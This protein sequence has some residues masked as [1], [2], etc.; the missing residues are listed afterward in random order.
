MSLSLYRPQG[1]RAELL[2]SVSVGREP[3]LR[4]VLERL[5]RW[6]PGAS[7]QHY[8]FIGPR[9]IGK[10]HL[11]RLIDHRTHSDGGL[12]Q[13]WLPILLA[14]EQY[15]V[16]RVSD[17]LLEMV[18]RLAE[19]PGMATLKDV[20]DE[21]RFEADDKRVCDRCLDAFRRLYRET[22]RGVLLMMENLDRLLEQQVR[23][24]SEIHRLRKILIEEDW[25]VTLCTSPTFLNAVSQPEEPF[26]EFFDVRPLAELT[27]DEQLEMLRRLAA[28]EGDPEVIADVEKY[29]SR[30]RA[31]HH[32]TGGSPRLTVM[33]YDLVAHRQVGAVR[34]EL[35]LLHD[36]LTPFYQD[37]MKEIS[38]QEAKVLET[39]ALLPEGA[40]PSELAHEARMDAKTVRATLTRLE[41]GGYVRREE[42]RRK[43]TVYIV[44][45]R[46]FRLWHQMNHSRVV[47]GRV[48]YLLE[49]FS[50]WYATR[51]ERDQIWEELV[52]AFEHGI[53]ESDDGADDDAL[54][55][56]QSAKLIATLRTA[57][58]ARRRGAAATL[59]G[60]MRNKAAVQPLIRALE[61]ADSIVRGSA[62]TAL[63]RLGDP[64]AVQPLIRALEDT[65]GYVRVSSAAA[66]GRMAQNLTYRELDRMVQILFE[67]GDR[68]GAVER[69]TLQLLP[70]LLKAA[71]RSDDLDVIL[72]KIR[73]ISDAL[74]SRGMATPYDVA[75][76]YLSSNR[77]PAVLERQ[78]PEIREAVMLLVDFADDSAEGRAN[79]IAETG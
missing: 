14:E 64:A 74:V 73:T 26:F 56:L 68:S 31:L 22:S 53:R 59:L 5:A 48:Q 69:Y 7:R 13:K 52:S 65:R 51:E 11:L 27:A 40:T 50:S 12:R 16:S 33:L 44:P 54:T 45:E 41:R 61:D 78:Q 32:F 79:R 25:L 42:R 71:L 20:Y 72:R 23:P 62:A 2:E 46:L 28:A 24:R 4:E 36:R 9:G 8:L 63:G 10:T 47:R 3:L 21:T 37:R 17:L 1:T 70:M 77:D 15:G 38:E 39:M 75:G 67:F 43:R 19:E 29:R 18:R 76:E 34:N 57:D 35:E 6:R 49:F 60:K 58:Q 66:L 55:A 30:L